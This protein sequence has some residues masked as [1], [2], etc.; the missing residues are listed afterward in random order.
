MQAA[1]VAPTVAPLRRPP[2]HLPFSSDDLRSAADAARAAAPRLL[3]SALARR[4]ATAPVISHD[5]VHRRERIHQ[6]MRLVVLLPPAAI[7]RVC[8]CQTHGD[9]AEL[10]PSAVVEH[11]ITRRGWKWKPSTI[12]DA[13]QAWARYLLWLDRRGVQHDG[14]LSGMTT[15]RFLSS[16]NASAIA[17]ASARASR[18]PVQPPGDPAAP[19]R[20]QQDGTH[21]ERGVL[22]KLKFLEKHFG[23]ELNAS[24]AGSSTLEGL[25]VHIRRRWILK[26]MLAAQT[27]VRREVLRS[28][29]PV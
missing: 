6:L 14:R 15:G 23:L 7:A 5:E 29:L 28:Q 17:R 11:I 25:H 4:S 8:G 26:R 16:V 13:V 10:S 20:R 22:D 27:P 9:A 3:P 2:E 19:R 21:A 12:R 1:V 24:S 18:V